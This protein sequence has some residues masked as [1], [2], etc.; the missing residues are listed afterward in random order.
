MKIPKQKRLKNPRV[1]REQAE[2]LARRPL[3]A[4]EGSALGMDENPL[5]RARKAL[6]ADSVFPIA[7][8]LKIKP[9]DIADPQPLNDLFGAVEE[10]LNVLARTGDVMGDLLVRAQNTLATGENDLVGELKTLRERIAALKLYV[11][12]ITDDDQYIAYS[13]TDGRSIDVPDGTAATYEEGEGAI[14]LPIEET[15]DVEIKTVTITPEE[16]CGP[17]RDDLLLEIKREQLSE[18]V[19]PE[20]GQR[21]Q[22]QHAD[23]SIIKAIITNVSEASITVDANHPLAGKDLTFEIELVE[24]N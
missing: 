20:I 18:D 8:P 6:A 21:L 5:R 3:T 23:G 2:Q 19:H 4:N 12:D 1:V 22:T 16:A 15:K 11:R 9:G 7:R 10:D 13:F 24:I 14:L 17:H